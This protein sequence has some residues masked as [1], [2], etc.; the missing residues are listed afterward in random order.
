M[1]CAYSV[2]PNEDKILNR[3]VLIAPDW[4]SEG[5]FGGWGG[6]GEGWGVKRSPAASDFFFLI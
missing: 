1:S 4:V 5:N 2:T 6:G 3:W